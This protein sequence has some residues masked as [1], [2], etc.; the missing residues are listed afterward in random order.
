MAEEVPSR[1][2]CSVHVTERVG[3]G[4]DFKS[5]GA[6]EEHVFWWARTSWSIECIASFSAE[7]DADFWRVASGAI[8]HWESRQVPHLP[9]FPSVVHDCIPAS[10]R[11]P[12]PGV[13]PEMMQASWQLFA[14][15]LGSY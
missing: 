10:L 12:N 14:G 5:K 1:P 13:M 11:P 2:A 8:L 7:S 15:G 6:S 3:R 4:L 9:I